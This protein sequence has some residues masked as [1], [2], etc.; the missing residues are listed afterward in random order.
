MAENNITTIDNNYMV[1]PFRTRI[2]VRNELDEAGSPFQS[3]S[4]SFPECQ[5]ASCP[6]Y[7][8]KGKNASEK[9]TRATY[10]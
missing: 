3:Q 1:C 7:D 9:C 10:S 8:S 6:Y 2:I 5:Y 4:T